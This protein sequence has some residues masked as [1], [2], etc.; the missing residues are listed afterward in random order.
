LVKNYKAEP[1]VLVEW[2]LKEKGKIKLQLGECYS[3]I[4]LNEV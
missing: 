2:V 3:T 1:N 4:D